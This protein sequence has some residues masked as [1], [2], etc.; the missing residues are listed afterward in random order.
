MHFCRRMDKCARIGG[1]GG[2]V[3]LILAMPVFSL[4]L[5]QQPFPT[6]QTLSEIE[7]AAILSSFPQTLQMVRDISMTWKA[8][9][10]P[11]ICFS[12]LLL[13]NESATAIHPRLIQGAGCLIPY[14]GLS[15]THSLMEL[16]ALSKWRPAV[17]SNG[18]LFAILLF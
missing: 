1:W 15:L 9:Q 17:I 7:S 4:E 18:C 6:K 8:G 16:P 3:K 10:F 13:H 14:T 2:G 12:K 5:L 11:P